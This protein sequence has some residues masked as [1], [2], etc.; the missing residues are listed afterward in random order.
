MI[1]K[2]DLLKEMNISYGQLYRWKREGLIPD[3]WFNKQAVSTGQETFFR[4]NLIVPRIEKILELKDKYQL[5]E[6]KA[7][8]S[9]SMEARKFSLR[10]VIMIEAIDPFVLKMYSKNKETF[11]IVELA[12]LSI[13]SN[14]QEVS[15]EDY[16][17]IDFEKIV[18][19]PYL[20]LKNWF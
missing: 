9:P 7:F 5:E 16:M 13:F 19:I 4:R 1:S 11:T 15:F 8:F 6:L 18:K 20:R 10:E 2:K 17:N 3:E 12:I 14:N